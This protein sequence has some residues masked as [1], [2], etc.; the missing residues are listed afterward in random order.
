MEQEMRCP[1]E[2]V[3]GQRIFT[4]WD[5]LYETGNPLPCAAA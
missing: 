3:P 4:L 5:K 2:V 1:M